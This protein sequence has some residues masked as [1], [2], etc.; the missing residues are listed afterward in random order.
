MRRRSA[1]AVA[2][3]A[4]LA[5][6]LS[7]L[8]VVVKR[9]HEI[10]KCK[11]R[12]V[13]AVWL[14]AKGFEKNSF[15]TSKNGFNTR[16]GSESHEAGSGAFSSQPILTVEQLNELLNS[17]RGN[18]G[19]ASKVIMNKLDGRQATP[20]A[21]K[22]H[23]KV[24]IKGNLGIRD[25]NIINTGTRN[26]SP[27]DVVWIFV[28]N[29][30]CTV[31]ENLVVRAGCGNPGKTVSPSIGQRPKMPVVTK[32]PEPKP[33]PSSASPSPV[34]SPSPTPSPTPT[35]TPTPAPSPPAPPVAPATASSPPPTVIVGCPSGQTTNANGV[36]VEPKPQDT[37]VYPVPTAKPTVP[38]VTV[39]AQ[40]PAPVATSVPGGNGVI[41]S[42]T[43]A[44]GSET[45]SNAPGASP[46]PL[47]P[48]PTPTPSKVGGS[49]SGTVT[50]F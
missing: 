13:V 33:S 3:V 4:L 19:K 43:K 7:V 18:T 37:T 47:T 50:G 45:G 42:P 38:A 24:D 10:A 21:V 40:T 36:C 32:S 30:N 15:D 5:L 35:E 44:P 48:Q 16:P 14:V 29:A 11:P 49:N 9:P 27:G 28:D 26:S 2:V 12:Q 25:N 23:D 20:V 17:S 8:V 1:S 6:L 41:D 22:F 46:A 34:A 31:I 39:P